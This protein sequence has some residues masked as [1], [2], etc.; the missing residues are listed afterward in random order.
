MNIPAIFE[1]YRQQASRIFQDQDKV[2]SL[3]SDVDRHLKGL[4]WIGKKLKQVPL[5]L[6]M[7]NH[8]YHKDYQQ[9]PVGT[10]LAALAALLY[11]VY[12]LDVIPDFIPFVG[13]IDDAA[14]LAFCYKNI[15]KDLKRYQKWR[16]LQDKT[17]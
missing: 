7:L 6:S 15:E 1:K 5:F 9:V 4:P 14:I 2:Q 8:Y 11:F 17:R 12:P 13:Y 3:L 16:K 10:I